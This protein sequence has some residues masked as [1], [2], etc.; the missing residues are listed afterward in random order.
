MAVTV[1]RK[2]DA[3]SPN[4]DG[5]A[6]S[7]CTLL[8]AVLVNGYV[9]KAAAGWTLTDNATTNKRLY[10]NTGG[11]GKLLMVDDTIG[12]AYANVLG[13]NNGT[14]VGN[15]ARGFGQPTSRFYKPDTTGDWTVIANA[16]SF[17][18]LVYVS[19][20]NGCWVPY[21]FGDLNAW[22]GT[23]D[24]GRCALVAGVSDTSP[25]W[26]WSDSATMVTGAWNN[27][28]SMAGGYLGTDNEY[29]YL[30]RGVHAGNG[31]SSCLPRCLPTGGTDLVWPNKFNNSLVL[32]QYTAE[33]TSDYELVN[34]CGASIRGDITG[35]NFLG[36]LPAGITSW[37]S[38][39]YSRIL[40]YI[41]NKDTY[42]L[43]SGPLNGKTFELYHIRHS[44]AAIKEQLVHAFET[45]DTWGN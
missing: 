37:T 8:D 35:W 30:S 33:M 42:S 26:G 5:S 2:S 4:F 43:S 12:T 31:F 29:D 28:I 21:F 23:G 3:N 11:S 9:G 22:A 45:S 18:L 36:S 7:L 19:T 17:I 44:T 13:Y 39:I 1:Y 40:P 14:T 38:D 32:R 10:K 16:K 20:W 24:A 15:A 41:V 27:A 34:G 25:L 6:G